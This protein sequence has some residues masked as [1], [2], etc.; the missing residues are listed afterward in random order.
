MNNVDFA[1]IVHSR[2]AEDFKRKYRILHWF[3]D[4]FIDFITLRLKPIL[5]SYIDGVKSLKS[6]D[7]INGVVIGIPMTAKQLLE[8]RS[9]AL[10]R[11][12][13]SVE[14]AK[15]YGAKRIALGA[16]TASLSKGGIDVISSVENVYIT[17]G[18]TFT[19]KNICDYVEYYTQLCNISK[20]NIRIGILGAAGSIGSSVTKTLIKLGYKNFTLID[21]ERKLDTL[22]KHLDS[23]RNI[24]NH[25]KINKGHQVRLLYECKIIIAATSSPEIVIRPSDVSYGTIIINDAQPSDVDPEIIRTRSDVTVVEGGVLHTDSVNCHFNFGL[26]HRTDIFSCL[27]EVILISA[28][29]ISEHKS[30]SELDH[31]YMKELDIASRKLGFK[32]CPQNINGLVK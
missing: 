17:N 28:L 26:H 30:I 13:Q 15:K 14:K 9:L 27:A 16:M 21:L 11:I 19:S 7:P 4:A 22:E 29:N 2:T 20:E 25:I 23:I 6:G 8:N 24:N 18:R 10:K 3:P 32:I 5:V 1:F 12:I 31:N